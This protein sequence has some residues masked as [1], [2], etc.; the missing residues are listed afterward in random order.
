MSSLIDRI[1]ASGKALAIDVIKAAQPSIDFEYDLEPQLET[2]V[3]Y[4]ADTFR[5]IEFL[6]KNAPDRLDEHLFTVISGTIL[7]AITISLFLAA[8]GSLLVAFAGDSLY[9]ADAIIYL[10][11][12]YAGAVVSIRVLRESDAGIRYDAI[13][14]GFRA[15]IS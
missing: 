3:G 1:C 11:L 15:L 5:S 9:L 8:V 10:L 14:Q 12:S 6:Q 2:I 13:M 4:I 7:A